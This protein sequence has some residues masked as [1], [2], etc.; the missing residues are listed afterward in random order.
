LQGLAQQL[1]QHCCLQG[2]QL[3]SDLGHLQLLLRHLQGTKQ[4]TAA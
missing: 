3:T 1:L 4:Q 2:A